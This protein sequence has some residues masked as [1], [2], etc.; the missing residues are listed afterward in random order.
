MTKPKISVPFYFILIFSK[1]IIISLFV[2]GIEQQIILYAFIATFVLDSFFYIVVKKSEKVK[3][4][5]LNDLVQKSGLTVNDGSK[6]LIDVHASLS[7]YLETCQEV[8]KKINTVMDV[9]KNDASNFTFGLRD[10]VYTATRINGSVLTIHEQIEKLETDI[11]SSMAA[12][13]EITRTIESFGQQIGTQSNSVMQTSAAI[14]E[15]DASIK[16]VRSITGKKRDSI[17]ELVTRTIDGKTQM[18]EMGLIINLVNDSID[19]IHQITEVIDGIASQTGL[20]SMN[21]AIEA[22]HAGDAGKGFAVV[23][24][25][26][27]TLSESTTENAHLISGSLKTIIS[28]I[29]NVMERSS[30]NLEIYTEIVDES[31]QIANAFSE[32]HAATEELEEGSGEIVS[33]TQTLQNISTSISLGAKEIEESAID[34]RNTIQEIVQKGKATGNETIRITSITQNL[35]LLFQDISENFLKYDANLIQTRDAYTELESSSN[36]TKQFYAIPIMIKHLLWI[37]RARGV[38]DGKI[39]IE[40]RAL[41]DHHSCE[42]GKWLA[43]EAPNSIK[44]SKAYTKMVESH[45]RLHF[46]VK[47]IIETVET[48]ERSEQEKKFDEL[49][50]SSVAILDFLKTL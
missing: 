6:K 33:A 13:E 30:R 10:S 26:I 46:L 20:L 12:V 49:L 17:T 27:R 38:I 35:N 1:L 40:K 14:E 11:L 7:S 24:E 43:T 32:I 19:D 37:I 34:L 44:T 31:S 28:N 29:K 9:A 45:E 39:D 8:R 22:A 18:E 16:S 47:E 15:M 5:E 4:R 3:K 2:L 21:A 42:L 41:V 50:D 36:K 48:S 23:A 25:E